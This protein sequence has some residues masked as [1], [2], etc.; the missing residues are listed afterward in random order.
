MLLSKYSISLNN[1]P[2]WIVSP[3][4]KMLSTLKKEYYSNFCTFEISSLVN[5][6]GHYLS[7]WL[8]KKFEK[9]TK[10][11]IRFTLLKECSSYFPMKCLNKV[12]VPILCFAIPIIKMQYLLL[13]AFIEWI[14]NLTWQNNFVF[15]LFMIF[16]AYF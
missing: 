3:F 10:T 11:T 2:L 16:Q 6:P 13:F 15:S 1:V 4:L 14:I 5:V 8:T 9:D 7:K 12:Y